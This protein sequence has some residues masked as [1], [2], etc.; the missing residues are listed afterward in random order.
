MGDSEYG[1]FISLTLYS[2]TVYNTWRLLTKAFR[3][4]GAVIDHLLIRGCYRMPL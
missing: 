2:Q 3:M 4:H 1:Y